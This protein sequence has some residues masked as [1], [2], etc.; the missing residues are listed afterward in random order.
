M[1]PTSRAIAIALRQA[2]ASSNPN[3]NGVVSN[4][5]V[6][7]PTSP[8][9]ATTVLA[10]PG[11][12]AYWRLGDNPGP[13][14]TDSIGSLD[15]TAQGLFTPNSPDLILSG[16]DG[17]LAL[18]GANDIDALAGANNPSVLNIQFTLTVEAWFTY[19]G[20]PGVILGYV[21]SAGSEGAGY[22]LAISAAGN[23]RFYTGF[24]GSNFTLLN[25]GFLETPSPLVPGTTYHAVCTYENP[26]NRVMVL[27][28]VVIAMDATTQPLDYSIHGGQ[29]RI[30]QIGQTSVNFSPFG[31]FNGTV[32]EAAIYNEILPNT[33]RSLHYQIGSNNPNINNVYDD[34][35]MGRPDLAGYW[36]LSETSGTV[37]VDETGNNDGVYVGSYTQ[38]V[39]GLVVNSSESAVDFTGGYINVSAT[40]LG[41][42]DPDYFG[43][44]MV[45]TIHPGGITN[46]VS[47]VTQANGS[48]QTNASLTVAAGGILSFNKFP[49]SN[50]QL[51]GP[52]LA[53]DTKYHIGYIETA[54][55]R[56]L[57]LN[58]EIIAQDNLSEVYTGGTN[59][60]FRIGSSAVSPTRLSNCVIHK[61]AV[62]FGSTNQTAHLDMAQQYKASLSTSGA[63]DAY[64]NTVLSTAF[65]NN[66]WRANETSGNVLV[67]VIDLGGLGTDITLSGGF[68]ID[69]PGL[70]SDPN[71]RSVELI[72]GVTE[73]PVAPM[74]A[75]DIQNFALEAWI[76]INPAG[77]GI[78]NNIFHQATASGVEFNTLLRVNDDDTVQFDKFPP[79]GN[80]LQSA[81][82][83]LPDTNYHVFYREQASTRFLYLNGVIIAQDSSSET[84]GGS[85]NTRMSF[86]GIAGSAAPLSSN[87]RIA[88]IAHHGGPVS[89][90]AAI[91]H[92][93]MGIA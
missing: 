63:N 69:Q 34:L 19:N 93:I 57:F 8:D 54:T 68:T 82:T 78:I 86:G 26:G 44:S 21:S 53:A 29:Q 2:G 71:S 27:N 66:Y 81:A 50:A 56:T 3:S 89:P 65:A 60:S 77:I 16:G 20:G 17:A 83:V 45:V 35:I 41:S 73:I 88:E 43:I 58:G 7:T 37:A 5:V 55:L 42:D 59:T 4:D 28:D 1:I 9:Y 12:V 90:F 31:A 36:K 74:G 75:G 14:F 38:G 52:T 67:D 15:L 76:R 11:L 24:A 85:A 49:P 10:E 48:T 64:Q 22:M 91:N 30:I 6:S 87:M 72:N 33:Q 80:A 51:S 46:G 62:F 32:D 13:I 23:F 18:A 47:L 39:P 79:S 70:I 25:N 61:V 40:P 84:Y 92:Y